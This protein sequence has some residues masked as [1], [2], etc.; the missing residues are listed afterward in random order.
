MKD[1]VSYEALTRGIRGQPRAVTK[2]LRIGVIPSGEQHRIFSRNPTRTSPDGMNLSENS[3]RQ[4]LLIM[5]RYCEQSGADISICR[6]LRSDFYLR[7]Y[8][9]SRGSTVQR[10]ENPEIYVFLL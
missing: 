4:T 1:E 8:S 3:F 9:I 2:P 5:K 10:T 7:L 6:A